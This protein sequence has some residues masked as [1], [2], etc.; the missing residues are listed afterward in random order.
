MVF[1]DSQ[2]ALR[3]FSSIVN[4]PRIVRE[5]RRCRVFLAVSLVW[6]LGHSNFPGELKRAG[7]VLP[8]SSSADLNIQLNS[9]K[10]AIARKFF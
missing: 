5:C 8:E 4:N 1:S 6:I 3:Y 10:L 7:A 2:A 9:V